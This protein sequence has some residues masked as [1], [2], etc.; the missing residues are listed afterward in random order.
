MSAG[1]ETAYSTLV[2][3]LYSLPQK[4]ALPYPTAA[5]LHKTRQ[6][7]NSEVTL[8]LSKLGPNLLHQLFQSV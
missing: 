5:N 8:S 6:E 7:A 2:T 3:T 1:R 4:F